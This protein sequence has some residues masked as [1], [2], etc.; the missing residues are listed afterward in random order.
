MFAEPIENI[1]P[2]DCFFYHAMDLPGLGV[3]QGEWDLRGKFAE[4][5][6]HVDFTGKRVLDIGA[7]SGFLS[8]SAEAAG[9]REVVSFDLDSSYRQDF[10]PFHNK[11][12]F[13][14]RDAFAKQHDL[15]I[16]K[17]RNAYWLSHR[18][19]GSHAKCF[20]GDVYALP[21]ELGQFDVSIVGSILEHLADPIKA[22]ASIS[23]RTAGT[24]VIINGML[25]TD[26]KIAEFLGDCNR[27]ETDYVFWNYSRGIYQHVLSMLNF[28]VDSI[29]RE[30]FSSPY[31]QGM[32][33]R[34][35]I[36][37]SRKGE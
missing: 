20:Y 31:N 15:W 8:F 16:A 37:A 11:L 18:L 10:L 35:I 14:D 27:P 5:T 12:A 6:G 33:E 13:M 22:L 32:S 1:D 36:V 19:L 2:S 29:A 21:A 3:V 28:R 4:Y 7:A 17:W 34:F 25:D 30:Q 26:D 23:R 9:A 24:I